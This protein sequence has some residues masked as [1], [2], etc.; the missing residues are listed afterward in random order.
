MASA[1]DELQ[2]VAT[3]FQSAYRTLTCAFFTV[4]ALEVS[5]SLTAIVLHSI[6]EPSAVIYGLAMT[7]ES[8]AAF[9]ATVIIFLPLDA[10]R[11]SCRLAFVEANTAGRT[12]PIATLRRLSRTDTLWIPHPITNCPI[13]LTRVR[14]DDVGAMRV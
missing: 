3:R 9:L 14:T 10:T 4:S 5:F 12:I 8:L 1:Y 13:L 7:F 11:R 6:Q 2:C